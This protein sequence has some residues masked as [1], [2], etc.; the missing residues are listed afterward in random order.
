M[1]P[2]QNPPR[3]TAESSSFRP[4]ALPTIAPTRLSLHD[5][6]TGE[7]WGPVTGLPT[8]F[9]RPLIRFSTSVRTRAAAWM[10]R[11]GTGVSAL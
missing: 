10:R 3:M 7:G 4:S 5:L 2:D 6:F 11:S 8:A 9:G 1:M